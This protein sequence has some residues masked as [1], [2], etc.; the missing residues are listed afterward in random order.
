MNKSTETQ[1]RPKP[2][3]DGERLSPFLRV[4]LG[5]QNPEITSAQ[6]AWTQPFGW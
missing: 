1:N 3:P 2:T 5:K 4:K 6:N